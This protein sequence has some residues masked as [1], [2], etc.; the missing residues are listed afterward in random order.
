MRMEKEKKQ[1]R[2]SVSHDAEPKPKKTPKEKPAKPEKTPSAVAEKKEKKKLTMEDLI[3][4]ESEVSDWSDI[5]APTYKRKKRKGKHVLEDS[6]DE[7][8]GDPSVKRQTRK[9]VQKTEADAILGTDPSTENFRFFDD[10]SVEQL[11]KIKDELD[12]YLQDEDNIS[13][14][15]VC[16]E[17]LQDP[18][19]LIYLSDVEDAEEVRDV[20]AKFGGNPKVN[21]NPPR[22][23]HDRLA[24]WGLVR[25]DVNIFSR[26]TMA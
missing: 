25:R 17:D 9:L 8:V 11:A 10:E 6:S 7:E 15:S 5:E 18:N 12:G 14:S 19:D 1:A 2:R 4:D 21:P 22:W 23:L 16:S 3:N 24:D 26:T 13:V 20:L